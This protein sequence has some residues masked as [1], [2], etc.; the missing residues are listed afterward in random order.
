MLDI[1]VYLHQ[2]KV[3]LEPYLYLLAGSCFLYKAYLISLTEFNF[4]FGLNTALGTLL[5]GFMLLQIFSNF[6]YPKLA[7]YFNSRIGFMLVVASLIKLYGAVTEAQIFMLS[8]GLLFMYTN[9]LE[10]SLSKIY[11]LTIDD[12]GILVRQSL[13]AT[14]CY[15][16]HEIADLDIK[17]ARVKLTLNTGA[18]IYLRVGREY[19]DSTMIR[20]AQYYGEKLLEITKEPAMMVA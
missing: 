14:E 11:F 13:L 7:A 16:W 20:T 15:A 19:T 6:N 4:W 3:K 5:L 8:A 18:T 17:R 9:T 10:E 2:N 12:E 1:K